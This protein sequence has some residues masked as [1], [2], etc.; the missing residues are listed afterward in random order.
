[1]IYW[2]PMNNIYIEFSIS[3]TIATNE[4][5]KDRTMLELAQ[6]IS[7]FIEN[8]DLIKLDNSIESIDTI[9]LISYT[10]EPGE[11]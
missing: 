6:L 11:A 2:G 3:G 4:T 8:K 5:D 7:K 10:Q 1:M 9:D